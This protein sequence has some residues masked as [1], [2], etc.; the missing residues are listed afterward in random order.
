MLNYHEHKP[1]ATRIRAFTGVVIAASMLVL[2]QQPGTVLASNGSIEIHSSCAIVTGCF[3]GDAPG[4][5]VTITEPGHYKLTSLIGTT[6]DAP[7]LIT[8]DS[9][10][11]TVDLNGFSLVGLTDCT[12]AGSPNVT[13]CT[14]LGPD[15]AV[16][17]L[18]GAGGRHRF[19]TVRNGI[20]EGVRGNGIDASQA[21]STIVENVTV[22][23]CGGEG[24]IAA[25]GS[26]VRRSRVARC[27]GNGVRVFRDVLVESVISS[28]NG[29]SGFSADDGSLLYEVKAVS[30][31]LQGIV[32]GTAVSILDSDVRF[33]GQN[34]ILLDSWG[35]ASRV[36]SYKNMQHGIE[37]RSNSSVR[38]SVFNGNT[39]D[40]INCTFGCTI[41][42]NLTEVNGDDGIHI[43]GNGAANVIANNARGNLGLGL[44]TGGN[45]V[46]YSQNGL[47][48]NTVAPT[49]GGGLS[50]SSGK[51]N[52]NGSL[53]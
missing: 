35:L 49:D 15:T 52:C 17:V 39:L 14:P 5:P 19:V 16:R 27:G 31:T 4:L 32:A 42:G 7:D 33:S 46:Y 38:D 50:L 53:C 37:M 51:N 21:F 26:T 2:T 41:E 34:G 3:P 30:N 22:T 47:E 18:L 25:R 20:I 28:K 44:Q 48:N 8:I 24:I 29:A 11:V 13:T 36:T 40:G 23:S 43:V 45:A 10:N 1:C 12:A 9:S 6:F